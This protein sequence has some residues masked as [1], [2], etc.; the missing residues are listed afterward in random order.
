[1]SESVLKYS[2]TQV[3]KYP[4]TGGP[5]DSSARV[6]R[7]AVV[8]PA[9]AAVSVHLHVKNWPTALPRANLVGPISDKV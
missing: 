3:L 5:E 7:W 4:R 2:S 8:D 1:M 9:S 6:V